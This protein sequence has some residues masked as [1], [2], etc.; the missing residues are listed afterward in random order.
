MFTVLRL[1]VAHRAR[2]EAGRSYCE[3]EQ[4]L[5]H[6]PRFRTGCS[7]AA[8]PTSAG[9]NQQVS[10]VASSCCAPWPEPRLRRRLSSCALHGW[11]PHASKRAGR[12]DGCTPASQPSP[13]PAPVAP[14]CCAEPSA[15]GF[16][17]F[18]CLRRSPSREPHQVRGATA[19]GLWVEKPE[20]PS[21]VAGALS[22]AAVEWA[23][24]LNKN[25]GNV[26]PT[27]YYKHTGA[28]FRGFLN[29]AASFSQRSRSPES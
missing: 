17:R 18:V 23:V 13:S 27:P 10:H 25:S 1:Q 9:R 8:S 14:T 3:A 22:L 29:Q 16:V 12:A 11:E 21:A 24:A 26:C 5:H 6:L 15:T 19:W 2:G 4:W 28:T 20:L 7:G